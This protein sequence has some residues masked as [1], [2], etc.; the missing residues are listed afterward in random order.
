MP[1]HVDPFIH[2]LKK[3]NT[4]LPAE[5]IHNKIQL[6][7][8]KRACPCVFLEFSNIVNIP[9]SKLIVHEPLLGSIPAAP[10]MPRAYLACHPSGV[11]KLAPALTGVKS[12]LYSHGV[13]S[14]ELLLAPFHS[15]FSSWSVS[16]K[17]DS[18]HFNCMKNWNFELRSAVAILKMLTFDA[19]QS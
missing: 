14:V 9:Q 17:A 5:Y 19:G 3:K 8:D 1:R 7:D 10:N 6:E 18:G 11:S 15:S 13:V 2:K 12:P 16:C 4:L